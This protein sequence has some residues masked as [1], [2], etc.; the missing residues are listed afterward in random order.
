MALALTGAL[1][2]SSPVE[3]PTATISYRTTEAVYRIPVDGMPDSIRTEITNSGRDTISL[4]TCGG[5]FEDLQTYREGA[6]TNVFGSPEDC[7]PMLIP[8][9]PRETLRSGYEIWSYL[10]LK[11]GLYRLRVRCFTVDGRFFRFSYSNPFWIL[12]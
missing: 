9:A 11:P 4:L 7:L 6:W 5:P 12:E 10:E 3:P 2:C 8:V 1:S